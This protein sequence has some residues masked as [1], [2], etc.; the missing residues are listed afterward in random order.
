MPQEIH[1]RE[2]K[3]WAHHSNRFPSTIC[4]NDAYHILIQFSHFF[5][6]V[7]SLCLPF[8]SVSIEA[9]TVFWRTYSIFWIKLLSVFLFQWFCHFRSGQSQITH[10]PPIFIYALRVFCNCFALQQ[11][12]MRWELQQFFHSILSFEQIENAEFGHRVMCLR[13]ISSMQT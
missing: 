8:S 5:L 4:A 11:N 10:L 9:T 12:A 7:C 1:T 13:R 2:Q 3:M 6:S